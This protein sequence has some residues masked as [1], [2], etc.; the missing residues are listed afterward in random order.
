MNE[1]YN[2]KYTIRRSHLRHFLQLKQIQ[3]PATRD[4]LQG[5]SNASHE[6]IRQLRAEGLPVDHWN[7]LIVH[8]IHERLNG[9]TGC[10]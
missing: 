2:K 1:V 8:C 6:M 5:L 10:R 9:E 4:E 3:A 7:F